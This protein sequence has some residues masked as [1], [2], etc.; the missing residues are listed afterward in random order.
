MSDQETQ[1]QWSSDDAAGRYVDPS[2]YPVFLALAGIGGDDLLA[3][4]GIRS[5]DGG[6]T[7]A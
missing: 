2:R 3:S 4:L 1:G 7:A 5:D 6:E